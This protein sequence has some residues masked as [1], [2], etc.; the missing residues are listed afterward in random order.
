[1]S[2]LEDL[3]NVKLYPL[4]DIIPQNEKYRPLCEEISREQERLLEKLATEDKEILQNYNKLLHEYERMS[5]YANFS[6]GFRLGARLVFEIFAEK[7]Q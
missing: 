6:F 3:Y 5:E 7:G 1:M 4:E 2:I